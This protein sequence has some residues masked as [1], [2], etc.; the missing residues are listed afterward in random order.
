MGNQP[1]EQSG[2]EASHVRDVVDHLDARTNGEVQDDPEDDLSD[3][4]ADPRL[5]TVTR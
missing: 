2:H 1:E 5:V 3:Q 4:P